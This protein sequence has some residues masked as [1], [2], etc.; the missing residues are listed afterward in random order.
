MR[1]PTMPQRLRRPLAVLV[2]VFLGLGGLGTAAGMVLGAVAAG[3]P[4]GPGH[5][6]DAPRVPR[7][8]R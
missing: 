2:A 5:H 8:D 7:M 4:A 6:H 3:P 1:T